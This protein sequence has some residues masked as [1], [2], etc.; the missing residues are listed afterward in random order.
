MGEL[1]TLKENILNGKRIGYSSE[2]IFIVQVGR[3]AKGSYKNRYVIKGDL[4]KAIFYY[5]CINIGLGYKKRL[6][7]PSSS[8]NPIL[9]R[10]SHKEPVQLTF[11]FMGKVVRQV[12]STVLAQAAS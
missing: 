10:L 11:P 4:P 6:L 9:H 8:R 3:G 2:T 5:N 12:K 7:M 1:V